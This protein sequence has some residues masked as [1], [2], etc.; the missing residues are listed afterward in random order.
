MR[1]LVVILLAFVGLGVNAQTTDDLVAYYTFNDSTANDVTGGGSNG[2]I[3]GSPD[4]VCGVDGA[5]MRL[6]GAD[7]H[8]LLLGIIGNFF[9]LDDFTMSFYFRPVLINS[10]QTIFSKK[11]ACNDDNAFVVRYVPNFNSLSIEISESSTKKVL[12]S[13]Q[14]DFNKCWQHAT[15]VRQ[16]GTVSVYINGVFAESGSTNGRVNL[17]NNAVMGIAEGACVGVTD[18]P[19]G[20][21]LD[22]VRI[23]DRALDRD[24]IEDLYFPLEP[25][26]IIT[27]DTTVFL[28]NDVSIETGNTCSNVFSWTPSAD[29]DDPNSLEPVI[30][31]SATQVYT[32]SFTDNTLGC[33]TQDSIL[34]TVIDP[35]ELDCKEA[36]LPNAF[37]PN[38]DGRNDEFGLSNPYAISDLISFEIFDRWGGLVFLTDDPFERWDGSFKGEPMNPGVLLYKVRFRCDG[39]ELVNVGSVS[40]IR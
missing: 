1:F 22:E 26:N 30:S 10:V 14:L 24:E 3:V 32:L 6:D 40:L 8:V 33:T 27:Q 37:T 29:L 13:P 17:T 23:Y 12:L 38:D 31:P 5:A 2:A 25:D 16:G 20:G 11:E 35:S 9:E 18:S 21:I 15:I 4:F 19:F 7:D 36:F 34:I 39:E 28:G